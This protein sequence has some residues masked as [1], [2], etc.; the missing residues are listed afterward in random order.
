MCARDLKLSVLSEGKKVPVGYS[1]NSIPFKTEAFDGVIFFAHRPPT[2]SNGN[3]AFRERMEGKGSPDWLWEVQLHGRFLQKPNGPV[4]LRAELRD[5]PMQLG[6]V[7]RALCRG[8]L[9]FARMMAQRRGG[10]ICFAFGDEAKKNPSI[11]LPIMLLD[12]IFVADTSHPL[13]VGGGDEP[14]GTWR[15]VDGNWVSIDRSSI[16]FDAETYVTVVLATSFIDWTN[17]Q[18]SSIPGLGT[19]SLETFWGDQGAWISLC[20]MDPD[21][22]VRTYFLE[23]KMEPVKVRSDTP[24]PSTVYDDEAER[25]QE[26]LVIT[27]GEENKASPSSDDEPEEPLNRQRTPY[28][29][30]E[31]FELCEEVPLEREWLRQ[32][33]DVTSPGAAGAAEMARVAQIEM[34]LDAPD[35]GPLRHSLSGD[36]MDMEED[37]EI[38]QPHG[39][40]RRISKRNVR[41]LTL[42]WYLRTSAGQLWWCISVEG[43]PPCWR[44]DHQISHLC[45]VVESG[46]AH[47]LRS[48]TSVQDMETARRKATRL[49]C[50]LD[51]SLLDEFMRID[52]PLTSLLAS[53]YGG[54]LGVV[55]SEG[56]IVERKVS[57]SEARTTDAVL[58]A[59]AEV[60]SKSSVLRSAADAARRGSQMLDNFAAEEAPLA[61]RWKSD[62]ASRS[63][64]D[65]PQSYFS[66]DFFV[67]L[68]RAKAYRTSIAGA[69][70]V[71]V[72]TPQR[73]FLFVM[74][75]AEEA[76]KWAASLK[77]QSSPSPSTSMPSPWKDRL[78][79]WPLNRLVCNDFELCMD[80][81]KDPLSLSAK[82]LRLAVGSQGCGPEE[83]QQ[84][85]RLSCQL[86]TVDLMPLDPQDL[87]SFWMN[88]YHSLLVHACILYSRPRNLRQLLGFYN[89]CSYVVAGH[90]FSLAEL[91]HLVLRSQMAPASA[92]LMNW[93]VRVWRRDDKEF[94]DRP[95]MQAP[96]NPSSNFRC[97]PD[98]RLN[99]VLCAGNL[100]SS[101]KIPIFDRMSEKAFDEL[102]TKSMEQCLRA[103]GRLDRKPIQLPYVLYRFRQDAPGPAT[104]G[105][106]RRWATALEP[107]LQGT[108]YDGRVAYR[109]SYNWTMR[110]RL[111]IL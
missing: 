63:W 43:W 103:A 39:L 98:W 4:W 93:L 34:A 75:S 44:R 95:A 46:K 83:V 104:E 79:R 68:S 15:L 42:P 30:M 101:S 90:I 3:W 78:R 2:G 71:A 11:S 99:M 84:L 17:W 62:T 66:E 59:G 61:V 53:T 25:A 27:D 38:S 23:A 36:L 69:P 29:E 97:R 82:L 8:I 6:L 58:R 14:K 49:L 19:L 26:E 70:A 22:S 107:L 55:E 18:L 76:D 80:S 31:E 81:S 21:E 86:K 111:E 20:E 73:Q 1:G 32:P 9:K 67:E 35:V 109:S 48:G 60:V 106:D 5:S 85:T 94:E 57:V 110:D 10:D 16:V 40:S 45:E 77:L 64:M 65:R 52:V 108:A 54:W 87:W 41:T 100:A 47:L 74:R 92:R 28:D 105:Y 7:S 88:V 24:R 13:P 33:V 91:E 89:N 56:R 37:E 50:Q 102:M 72:T 51:P 12:R 96:Y